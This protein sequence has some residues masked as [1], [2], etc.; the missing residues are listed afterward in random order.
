EDVWIC[1]RV[2]IA[3]HWIANHPAGA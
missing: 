3:R 1:R 2:D